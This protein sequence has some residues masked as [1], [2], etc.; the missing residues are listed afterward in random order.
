M[1]SKKE[2]LGLYEEIF[3]V[4]SSWNKDSNGKLILPDFLTK[5]E[6]I[7]I[8]TSPNVDFTDLKKEQLRSQVINE[9]NTKRSGI[10]AVINSI[11]S[12]WNQR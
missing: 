5:H 3:E 1:D 6:T 7:V 9:K 8:D 2:T 10:L 12:Q 11:F 4:A